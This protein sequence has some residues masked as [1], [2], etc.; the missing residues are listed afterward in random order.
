MN[1]RPVAVS[2]RHPR[3]RLDRRAV[4][5]LI[6]TLDAAQASFA[7]RRPAFLVGELSVAFLT[8]AALARLHADFLGD[9]ATTDVITFEGRPEFGLAGEI[10]VSADTAARFARDH[11]RDFSAELTLYVVHGW[12]HLAGYDDLEPAKKRVMRRA[13]ARALR[14][15]AR[16]GVQPR[17]RLAA[18]H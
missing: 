2:N 15:V 3:L 7:I 5:R 18:R 13:E 14:L 6:A 9:P 11:G 1:A 10:C 16:N 8:D 12:L 4:C 17:F